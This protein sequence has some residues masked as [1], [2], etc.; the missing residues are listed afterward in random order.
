MP[1]PTADIVRLYEK[2]A[3]HYDITAN[4]YYLI[5]FREWAYRQQ[6]VQALRLRYG[7]TVVELGCGTGLNFALLEKAIGPQGTII[8]VD[9]TAAMLQQAQQ[10]VHRYGWRNVQLIQRDAASYQFP[11]G[12]AGVLST[13]TL[14]FV[15]VYEQVIKRAAV[16]LPPGKRFVLLDLKAPTHWPGWLV[17]CGVFLTRPFG[18]TGALTQRHPWETLPRY[19]AHVTRTELYFGAAYIA[20]GESTRRMQAMPR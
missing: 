7:D 8:G 10:R 20:T 6:A 3:K 13:F 11:I 5:G 1:L 12:I 16:A 4:L 19:F 14:T 18:V 2:R 15:P 9:I 17:K